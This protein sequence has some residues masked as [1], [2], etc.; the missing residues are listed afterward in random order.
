MTGVSL[1]G[2][3]YHMSGAQVRV[4]AAQSRI[5]KGD[6]NITNLRVEEKQES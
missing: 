2:A 5:R 6:S 4:I 3:D 1:W